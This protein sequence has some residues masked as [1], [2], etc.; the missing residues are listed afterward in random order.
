MEM[1][2]PKTAAIYGISK[3]WEAEDVRFGGNPGVALGGS[4]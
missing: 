2:L 1:V 4:V 3:V